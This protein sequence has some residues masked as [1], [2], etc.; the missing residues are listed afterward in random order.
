MDTAAVGRTQQEERAW[1]R[2]QQAI[3]DGVILWLAARTLFSMQPDL[4]G[5]PCAVPSRHG[6]RGGR[7]CDGWYGA[8]GRWGLRQRR[9]HRGRVSL[10]DAKPLGQ[11]GDAIDLDAAMKRL[12]Q[13]APSRSA[14][15][16]HDARRVR[17]M[18]GVPAAAGPQPWLP[19]SYW[20]R[21]SARA[22][23]GQACLMTAMRG[24]GATGW[25]H[26]W[27]SPQN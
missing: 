11:R 9:D 16:Q 15:R 22:H 5:R 19:Q 4:G 6:H 27:H 24:R 26:P 18:W 14:S 17:G 23:H 8:D 1:G 12:S 10:R 21:L 20:E 3:V 2:V 7:R 13:E 25:H